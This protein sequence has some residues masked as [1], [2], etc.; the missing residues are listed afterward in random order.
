MREDDPIIP[1]IQANFGVELLA[2]ERHFRR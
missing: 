1:T 2:T